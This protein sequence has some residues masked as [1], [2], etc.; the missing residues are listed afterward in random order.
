MHF[1]SKRA[2]TTAPVPDSWL[3]GAPGHPDWMNGIA[4][5][6]FDR[7][8]TWGLVVKVLV[9]EPE[10]DSP[11]SSNKKRL[12]DLLSL[13]LVN[14]WF[15]D[16][17]RRERE[18]LIAAF[19]S[20]AAA[21]A[22]RAPPPPDSVVAFRRAVRRLLEEWTPEAAEAACQAAP[23]IYHLR[24]IRKVIGWLPPAARPRGSPALAELVCGYLE[25]PIPFWTPP[26]EPVWHLVAF[27][28]ADEALKSAREL[29]DKL[30][31]PTK[32]ALALQAA[33]ELGP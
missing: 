3:P 29:R 28:T 22:V 9:G 20:G 8:N 32:A 6:P 15:W 12:R 23:R 31:R 10:R 25:F 4:G 2:K 14:R 26:P 13:C 18:E 21:L 24:D 7:A 5:Q 27:P 17:F 30:K 11:Y 19:V 1:R 16:H 33:A